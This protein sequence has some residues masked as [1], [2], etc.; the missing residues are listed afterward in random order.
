MQKMFDGKEKAL[1]ES[2]RNLK[3]IKYLEEKVASQMKPDAKVK[4]LETSNAFLRN[5][6]YLMKS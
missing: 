1:K 4:K 6:R 3:K 2:K 5:Y